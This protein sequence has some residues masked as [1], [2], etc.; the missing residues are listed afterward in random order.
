M[1][2]IYTA[3][4]FQTAGATMERLGLRLERQAEPSIAGAYG[5]PSVGFHARDWAK[6]CQENHIRFFPYFDMGVVWRAAPDYKFFRSEWCEV[7]P[8]PLSITRAGSRDIA[9]PDHNA[10]SYRDWFL[11][12]TW[13]TFHDNPWLTANVA[14]FYLDEVEW[15][16]RFAKRVGEDG[17]LHHRTNIL[18]V[19]ELQKRF[20]NMV[21]SEW[22]DRFILNHQSGDPQFSHLGFADCYITGEDFYSDPFITR[23]ANYY[24]A[25]DL[26]N[27]RA[28]MAAAAWGVPVAFLSMA[29]GSPLALMTNNTT[30]MKCAEHLAGMLLIHDVIPWPA[31]T[32]P[33]PFDR[34]DSVKQTFGW[35]DETEF[36]GYWKSRDVVEL[37]ADKSPVVVSVFKRP[38]KVL[39]AV[40]NNSDADAQVVIKPNWTKLGVAEPPYLADA[41]QAIAVETKTLNVPSKTV[42]EPVQDHAVRLKVAARNFRLL[43]AVQVVSTIPIPMDDTFIKT[44]KFPGAEY[45]GKPFWAWNG[46][47]EEGELRRQIGLLRQMGLGGFF[48]HAQFGLATPY[49]SEEW[50]R[51][52]NACADEA[53][54]QGM[55]AWLYD[56]DRW[57]SGDAGGLVTRDGNTRSTSCGWSWRF[58]PLDPGCVGGVRRGDSRQNGPKRSFG[59]S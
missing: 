17:Q 25:M 47:L 3:A 54:R 39:F 31:N 51:L 16:G 46:K 42:H 11:W 48:M 6:N 5:Y 21:K 56:E 49:L 41:Y 58:V 8:P 40:M 53:K 1:G 59:R 38:G 30:G 24:R 10:A 2:S 44:F 35:D 14:G 19:R 18:G 26:D 9:G 27:C 22:P 34:L 52:V 55:E 37:T 15:G 4:A 57:P 28:N 13:R 29:A 50:F 12:Q 36:I 45:R 23:D 20:Y 7:A 32:N 33:V 43:T